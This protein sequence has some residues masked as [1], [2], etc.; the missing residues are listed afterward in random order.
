MEVE[1]TNPF[2]VSFTLA[3]VLLAVLVAAPACRPCPEQTPQTEQT[4]SEQ[5]PEIVVEPEVVQRVVVE[6]IADKEAIAWTPVK[7]VTVKRG[8]GILFAVEHDTAWVLI[9]DGM[10]KKVLGGTDWAKAKSF[11]AFK[12]EK[13]SAVVLVP[14]DYPYSEQDVE[15]HYSILVQNADGQWE[16]VHGENPPPKIIIPAK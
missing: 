3:A 15:F 1:M 13:D 4:Q 9:P 2:K 6:A 14:E 11:I 8:E 5:E 16:Y 7:P 10:I 12:V